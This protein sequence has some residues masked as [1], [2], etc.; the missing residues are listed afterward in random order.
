M[1]TFV[2]C[3]HQGQFE[4]EAM[5]RLYCGTRG[6]VIQTTYAKL[7]ESIQKWK[8][9]SLGIG[10]VTYRDYEAEDILS[11]NLYVPVMSKRLAFSHEQEARIVWS[12]VGQNYPTENTVWNNGP[13]GKPE[14]VGMLLPW[15]AEDLVRKSISTLTPIIGMGM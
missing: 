9:P 6:V 15:N 3:W 14:P 11:L 1:T 4:S 8:N 5:W 10:L 13:D 12:M 7:K 2:N